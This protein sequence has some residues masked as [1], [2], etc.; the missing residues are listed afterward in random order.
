[1]KIQQLFVTAIISLGVTSFSSNVFAETAAASATEGY[2][3]SSLAQILMLVAF[4][5]I[6]YF[7]V[8][9]PQSKRVKDHRDL[10]TK[11]QKG[12]E[13]LTAGGLLGKVTR[14]NDDFFVVSIAE[15]VEVMVQKQAISSA[16]PKG[17]MKSIN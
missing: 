14:V 17:T 10:V 2:A 16:L 6:F 8:F 1:M 5:L 4:G 11:I 9:R 12:D 3:N 7:M 13:V 15:G